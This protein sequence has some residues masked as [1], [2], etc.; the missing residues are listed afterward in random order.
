MSLL[1]IIGMKVNMRCAAW[2]VSEQRGMNVRPGE[3]AGDWQVYYACP[4]PRLVF[5]FMSNYDMETQASEHWAGSSRH[6]IRGLSIVLTGAGSG[7]PLT[8]Q[9]EP[10]DL[11]S[12]P[13]IA[14]ENSGKQRNIPGSSNLSVSGPT[15]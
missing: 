4:V 9:A 10:Q 5:L 1:G 3:Q 14:L 6:L 7:P 13:G 8:Q 11:L 15:F 12:G 2:G